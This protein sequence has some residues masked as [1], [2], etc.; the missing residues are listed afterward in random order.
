MAGPV[1]VR[2]PTGQEGQRRLRIVR[3][4]STGPAR[5]RRAMML[6]ASAGGNR[7][8][9]DRPAGPGRREHRPRPE[10]ASTRIISDSLSAPTGA[11]DRR[12]AKK[13]KVELCFTPAC[14]SWADPI[15]ARFG[16]LRQFAPA[17]SH[18]PDHT[19]QTRALHRYL[20]RRNAEARHPDPLAAQCR[21]R[22][23]VRSEKGIRRGGRP[24]TSGLPN[25]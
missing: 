17:G 24:R 5:C 25:P 4:G 22:V 23:R 14:A 16:P 18:H 19:V 8:P 3:R 9:V 7:G 2:G 15:G 6:S 11:D 1:R 21:E 10:G 13:N 20:R 12:W